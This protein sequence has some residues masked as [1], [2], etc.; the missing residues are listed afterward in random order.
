MSGLGLAARLARREVR[1]RPGRTALV[2]LLVALPVAG[3]VM[4]VVLFRTEQL[5]PAEQ[6]QREYGAADGVL[7]MGSPAEAASALDALPPDARVVWLSHAWTEARAGDLAEVADAG[8]EPLVGR[9]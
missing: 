3:M 2:A 8:G 4:S 9:A 5:T 7:H 1:R 6:W